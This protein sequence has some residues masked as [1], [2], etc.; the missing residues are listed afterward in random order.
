MLVHA[1]TICVS[2]FL[3]FQIQPMIAKMIL[4]WF[5]GS[6]SVWITS[7]LF[8]QVALL[9]GYLYAHWSIQKLKP[10]TQA[11]VHAC[12]IF[13]SLLM[14]PISPSLAWK[15]AGNE[16][17]VLRILGLMAVSIGL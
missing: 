12:L 3:L 9:C 8:F 6:A 5:G 14:L 10:G 15:P 4:P 2:A 17:P 11:A 13:L 1:A 16:D 7:M